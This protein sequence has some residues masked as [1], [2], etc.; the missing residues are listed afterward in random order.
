MKL[1]IDN[2]I[3]NLQNYMTNRILCSLFLLVI[4]G[5]AYGQKAK[6]AVESFELVDT[7]IT[8][9]MNDSERLD[10]NGDKC[11][12]IKIQ[13]TEKGF[14]FD[15]G[16]LGVVETVF[17]NSEHP[18]EIWLYV[19]NGVK[20]ITIQHPLLGTINNYDLGASVKKGRT[21]L[22][23]L[24]TDQVNTLVVDYN[25]NQIL[26]TQIEPKN[27]TFYLN[28]IKQI[29]DSVGVSE[30]V[31]PFGTHTYRITADDYHPEDGR[32]SIN[33]KN[34]K[35]ELNVKLKQAFGYLTVE[36]SKDSE[37]AT[38]YIDE[39]EVGE[40]PLLN[41]HIKSGKHNLLAHKKL[42]LPYQEEFVMTDSAF[43][44]IRPILTPNYADVTISVADAPQAEI[45]ADGEYVGTGLWHGRL[46][47]GK[48]TIEA[49]K[50]GHV[51]SSREA[52]IMRGEKANILLQ[53]PTPIL[54][55]LDVTSTPASAQVI[56][57][58][59]A[60]GTTPLKDYRLLIGKHSVEAA[61]KGYKTE[62]FDV[63]IEEGKT[64]SKILTLTDFCT[65]TITSSPSFASVYVDDK[66]ISQTPYQLNLVAGKYN[67]KVQAKGYSI[68]NK[69][70]NLDGNTGN[71][72]IKLRRDY[73][74]DDELYFQAGYNV[75]TLSGINL[76]VGGFLKRINLEANY[77]I[78][79]STSDKIYWNDTE[80]GSYPVAATYKPSGGNIKIGY[81]LKINNRMRITPQVG[82]Q[83]I[84]LK[85]KF[86]DENGSS[87]YYDKIAN[88]ASA[89]SAL[90]GARLSFAIT[91]YLGISVTPQYTIGISKSN[92]YKALSEVSNKFKGYTDGFGCGVNLNL[93]F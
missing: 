29:L 52:S 82:A 80:G 74:P 65:A 35:H 32:I 61:S 56:I 27:A 18:G 45:Y 7:D 84:E 44:R 47:T 91:K 72:Y 17:Q 23:K 5:I 92:G 90:I 71:M 73:T 25:N 54:G 78:G 70:L 63:Q 87:I 2:I 79:L 21:Y 34:Q 83:F 48:Y 31:L 68:Y 53:A 57:D 77:I 42:Y 86:E 58:G 20:K 43:I 19:P 26:R 33:S 49:R 9:I 22:L 50:E 12:L 36:A 66:Y 30:I 67:I 88:G 3:G 55:A 8:S 51:S 40:T 46:E 38:I 76:G 62:S 4:S 41:A 60:V 93:F 64:T 69:T 6:M 39:K 28:G 75:N 81:G 59:K 11:A 1:D 24:T 37:G 85:E 89:C 14:A 15:V 10:Q 13:T 16:S